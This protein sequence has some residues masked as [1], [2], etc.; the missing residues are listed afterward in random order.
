MSLAESVPRFIGKH[1]TKHLD[2]ADNIFGDFLR[3]NTF[4]DKRPQMLP[5]AL[6]GLTH[7]PRLFV[8]F[9]ELGRLSLRMNVI[10][11]S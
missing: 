5:M 1:T 11:G 9:L 2:I 4:C 10:A 6:E 3:E 7:C 8:R